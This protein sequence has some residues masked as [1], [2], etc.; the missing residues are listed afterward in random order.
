M[1]Q[2]YLQSTQVSCW[3]I[4]IVDRY[5]YIGHYITSS[6]EDTDIVRQTESNY[7]RGNILARKFK[8]CSI[9]I[10]FMLF[11]SYMYSLN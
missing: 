11:W 5:K 6:L 9:D 4:S 2:R 10:K 1:I 8:H 3:I 7:A